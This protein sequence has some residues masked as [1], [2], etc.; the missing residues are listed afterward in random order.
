MVGED[1]RQCDPLLLPAGE[2]GGLFALQSRQVE[3]GN[4]RIGFSQSRCAVFLAAPGEDILQDCHIGKQR[5][6]LEKIANLSLLGWE[7]D[8][9]LAVKKDM[10]V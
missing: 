7:V 8:P 6:L 10:A 2:G 4:L 3:A 1:P 5:V 9:P